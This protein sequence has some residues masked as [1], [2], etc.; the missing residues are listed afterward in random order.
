MKELKYSVLKVLAYFD[1]FNYPLLK[2]EIYYFL[3]RKI[4]PEELAPVLMELTQSG[5]IFHLNDFYSLHNDP[6]QIAK[7]IKEN[8]RAAVLLPKARMISNFLQCFPFIRAIGISGS[9]SKNVADPLADFDYFIITQTNRLWVIRT[10]LIL[11]KRFSALIGKHD[12]FCINYF[13]DE[14]CLQIPEQNIY[15]ATEILTLI[16]TRPTQT[17]HLF[18][19]NNNWVAQYYPNYLHKKSTLPGGAP[20][21]LI[22]KIAEFMLNLSLLNQIDNWLLNLMIK[23]LKKKKE[24]GKIVIKNGKV[25]EISIIDKHYCKQNPDFFQ[26]KVLNAY[27]IKLNIIMKKYQESLL[28]Y[29][30]AAPEL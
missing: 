17:T 5:I 18:L 14:S 24:A 11:I 25:Q 1:I 16:I 28:D 30:A 27:T 12:W 7:R 3:D 4:L 13:I 21:P 8:N 2:D 20:T 19:E 6:A 15:T 23:R 26:A 9:L 22:K 10:F 29:Q